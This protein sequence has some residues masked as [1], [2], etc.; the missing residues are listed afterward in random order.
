MAQSASSKTRRV[1]LVDGHAESL[2]VLERLMASSGFEVAT[3]RTAQAARDLADHA[4]FDLIICELSLPDGS[5]DDLIGKLKS[6]SDVRAI[7]L[8]ASAYP[9]QQPGGADAAF[10]RFIL[11]PC[12][13]EEIVSAIEGLLGHAPPAQQV[14]VVEE[15]QAFLYSLTRAMRHHGLGVVVA[16]SFAEAQAGLDFSPS[17]IVIALS[18]AGG[19]AIMLLERIRREKLPIKI[20]VLTAQGNEELL[21]RAAA[22]QPEIISE[23]PADVFSFVQRLTQ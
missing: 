10:D 2:S 21:D 23:R 5:G 11:K 12:R 18:T 6:G 20:A 3:A 22:F 14:L 9:L 19:D 17:W 4:P 7:A 15:D 16:D 8:S 13:F 1:L